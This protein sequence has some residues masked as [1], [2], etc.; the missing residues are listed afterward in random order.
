M[1]MRHRKRGEPLA[2]LILA[3]AVALSA[4]PAAAMA[5][6]EACPVLSQRGEAAAYRVE[7]LLFLCDAPPCYNI[8]VTALDTGTTTDVAHRFICPADPTQEAALRDALQLPIREP[9]SAVVQ[10]FITDHVVFGVDMTVFVATGLH[11]PTG[12]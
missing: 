2:A 8:Q 3:G 10:G 9:A 1:P 5:D 7:G 11:D 4:T 12:D 6:S